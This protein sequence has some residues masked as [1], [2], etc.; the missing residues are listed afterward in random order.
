MI[1]RLPRC[2]IVGESEQSSGKDEPHESYRVW[3]EPR[4]V[5]TGA[6]GSEVTAGSWLRR[7]SCAPAGNTLVTQTPLA[8]QMQQHVET[9]V[10]CSAR[11]L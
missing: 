7:S 2:D 9:L 5:L 3:G 8:S 4:L 10:R 6:A 11:A 1:V